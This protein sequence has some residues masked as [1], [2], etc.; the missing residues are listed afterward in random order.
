MDIYKIIPASSSSKAKHLNHLNF[1]H[2]LANFQPMGI[3]TSIQQ[4]VQILKIIER[5]SKK[6]GFFNNWLIMLLMFSNDLVVLSK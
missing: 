5:T 3:N 4:V 1:Q 2:I 6:G